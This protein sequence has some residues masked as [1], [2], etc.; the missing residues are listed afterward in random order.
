MPMSDMVHVVTH[1]SEL[2][3]S[4]VAAFDNDDAAEEF[5]DSNEG[6]LTIERVPL[7]SEYNEV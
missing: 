4:I 3:Q 7:E 6:E 5:V 2:E 1:K